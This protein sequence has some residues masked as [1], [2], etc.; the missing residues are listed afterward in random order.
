VHDP[1][2]PGE[3]V[4]HELESL[5]MPIAE[6]A[7]RLG[8]TRQQLYKVVKGQSAISPEMAY[9]LEVGLGSTAAAWLRMQAAYDLAKVRSRAAEIRVE[10]LSEA[11]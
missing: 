2:H 9:R 11:Q 4:A 1:A 6:A 5:G 10:P 8:V 3:L 7:R